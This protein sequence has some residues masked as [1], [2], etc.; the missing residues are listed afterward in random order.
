MASRTDRTRRRR[1]RRR[2]N[3]GHA[4]KLKQG[5]SST[6]SAREL[7]RSLGPPGVAARREPFSMQAFICE[8]TL[9]GARAG[10]SRA[11]IEAVL[12]PADQWMAGYPESTSPIWRYG[13]FEVHFDGDVARSLFTDYLEPL[14]AGQSRRLDPW[15]LGRGS[16]LTTAAILERLRAREVRFEL[17]DTAWGPIARV[18]GG[19]ELQFVPPPDGDDEDADPGDYLSA[20]TA[21]APGAAPNW[22]AAR[23]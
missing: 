18:E 10:M 12:G 11:E 5:R 1:A 6:L 17:I 20:I 3:A 15:I 16:S 22:R 21:Y 7:F 8:G 2:K 23:G 4:R 14:D 9:G 19:A 13:L